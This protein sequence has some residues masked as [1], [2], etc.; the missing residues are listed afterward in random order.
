MITESPPG[1]GKGVCENTPIRKLFNNSPQNNSGS[2][3]AQALPPWFLEAQR[4]A[5]EFRRTGDAKHMRAFCRQI[6]GIMAEVEKA[7]PR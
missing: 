7:L 5:I 2:V 3:I 1:K 6:S 4:I